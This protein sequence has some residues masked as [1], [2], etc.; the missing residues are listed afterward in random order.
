MGLGGSAPKPKPAPLP[1]PVSK[2]EDEATKSAVEDERRRIA[3]LQGRK[4]TITSASGKRTI[5]G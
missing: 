5:L 1:V 4:K 3:N 2:P